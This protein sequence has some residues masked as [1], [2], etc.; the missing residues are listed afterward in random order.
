M[1]SDY[2]RRILN[3]LE[4]ELRRPHGRLWL[5]L[6]GAR[7][8]TA[9]TALVTLVVLSSLAVISGGTGSLGAALLGV[10]V[11][12]LLVSAVRRHV[13]GPRARRQLRR[14]RRSRDSKPH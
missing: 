5:T 10:I 3:E 6:R 2:E 13:L 11:G 9:V 1:L 14:A 4:V 7:L 8:P 12:W